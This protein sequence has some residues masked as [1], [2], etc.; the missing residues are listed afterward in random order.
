VRVFLVVLRFRYDCPY[1]PN[2]PAYHSSQR[3][4]E[5]EVDASDA[6]AERSDAIRSERR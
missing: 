4:L 5:H 6:V 2:T 3:R 1:M